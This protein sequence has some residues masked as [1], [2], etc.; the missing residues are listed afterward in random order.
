[1]RQIYHDELEGLT[2]MK[3]IGS[4]LE[5][6]DNYI[7]DVMCNKFVSLAI[8]FEDDVNSIVPSASSHQSINGSAAT[9]GFFKE[10]SSELKASRMDPTTIDAEGSSSVSLNQLLKALISLDKLQI[11][12][13]MYK[14]RLSD[15]VRLIVRTCILEYLT[16]FDPTLVVD[17]LES[18]GSNSDAA[19]TNTPFAARVREMTNENFLSCLSMCYENVLI[20]LRK[21]ETV[22]QFIDSKLTDYQASIDSNEDTLSINQVEGNNDAIVKGNTKE[23]SEQKSLV[24]AM[25]ILSKSC[26]STACELSQR[27]IVQLLSLRKESYG[28][29]SGESHTCTITI[30]GR[31]LCIPILCLS[32]LRMPDLWDKSLLTNIMTSLGTA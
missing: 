20:A 2:S 15:S 12:M 6:Y 8:Q 13:N 28:R 7:S 23:L 30:T 1:M 25:I 32:L 31:Y 11:A 17:A 4:Q 21:A 10:S 3:A 24:T 14:S 19:D 27:S 9:T 16:S 22:H 29:M 18:S 5:K 26:L